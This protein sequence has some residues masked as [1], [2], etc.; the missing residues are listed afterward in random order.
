VQY[1]VVENQVG[2]ET[3]VLALRNS[4]GRAVAK[5]TTIVGNDEE[6]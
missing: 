1:I 5:A 6:T 3:I 4:C 2:I